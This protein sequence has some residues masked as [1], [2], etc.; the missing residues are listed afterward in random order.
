MYMSD[1][2]GIAELRQNLSKY[3][4]LVAEGESLTVTDHNRPVAVLGPVPAP[5]RSAKLQ[6]LIDEGKVRPA[7][8]PTGILPPPLEFD[9]PSGVTSESIFEELREERDV[10]PPL[11][12]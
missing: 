7:Q 3:L 11:D 8:N 1:S 5:R 2:V 10:G 9:P 12:S 4:K 6:R